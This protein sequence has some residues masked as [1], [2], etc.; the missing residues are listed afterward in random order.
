MNK[1]RLEA[2][3]CYSGKNKTFDDTNLN[4]NGFV[5]KIDV[6]RVEV[7]YNNLCYGERKSRKAHWYLSESLL[8]FQM[9]YD[10]P[11]Y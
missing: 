6:D 5:E 10:N 2:A 8:K 3:R 11:I 4:Q 7:A 9:G 1:E